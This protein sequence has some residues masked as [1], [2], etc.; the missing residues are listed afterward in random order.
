MKILVAAVPRSGSHAYCST[1]PV[2]HKLYECMN[3]EDMLLPRLDDEMIDFS[4]CNQLFLDSL[5]NHNWNLAWHNKPTIN[6]S[7]TMLDFDSNMK[8]IKI[9]HMPSLQEFLTSHETRWKNIQ[10]L[11]NWCIKLIKYQGVPLYILQKI[12]SKADQIIILRRRNKLNQALSII[13]SKMTQLWH[14]RE[15]EEIVAAAGHIDY[16]LFKNICVDIKSNDLWVENMFKSD[17]SE[18]IYYE[19]LDL[20]NSHYTKNKIELIYNLDICKKIIKEEL[21]GI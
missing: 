16:K 8:K 1:L 7:H 2:K 6:S 14:N 5:D 18:F 19:D 4:I 21:Y 9:Q 13:K 12:I 3:I 10:K 11:D 20:S 15:G 17:K